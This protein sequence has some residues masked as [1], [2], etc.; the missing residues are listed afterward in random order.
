MKIKVGDKV[1]LKDK[2]YDEPDF[3]NE[4]RYH[5]VHLAKN[6]GFVL[7]VDDIHYNSYSKQTRVWSKENKGDYTIPI[8]LLE[9]VEEPVVQEENTIDGQVPNYNSKQH[10]D[11]QCRIPSVFAYFCPFKLRNLFEILQ[12]IRKL[13]L[14]YHYI[15]RDAHSVN[16]LI[17]YLRTRLR[18]SS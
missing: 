7:P 1:R 4:D 15:S 17:I 3:K 6:K 18:I 16:I 11:C 10:E 8:S 2:F 12:D 9:K 5:R 14:S 13:N